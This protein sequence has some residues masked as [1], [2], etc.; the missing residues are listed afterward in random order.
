MQKI[1]SLL[2]GKSGIYSIMNIYNGKIYIGSSKDLY[3]RL[4]E[5]LHLLL[6]NSAHN[7]HLQSAWNKYGQECFIYNILELCSEESR[8]EREQFYMD[9][10]SPEYNKTP[11][12]IANFGQTVSQ[13]SRDKISKTLKEKYKSGEIKTYKQEHA[14]IPI[15]IYNIN[16]LKLVAECKC[17]ADAL[18][19]L[20]NNSGVNYKEWSL[21]RNT[22][23]MSETKLSTKE[24]LL[25]CINKNIK[26]YKG[27][28]YLIVEKNNSI[29]YYRTT[30]ECFEDTGI[31]RSMIMKNRKST[32]NNPYYPKRYNVKLYFSDVY[33]P[34]KG[35]AVP[36]EESLEELSGKFEETPNFEETFN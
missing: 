6:R 13:E 7:K 36:I 8:F 9:F 23:T 4:Y 14:W 34:V 35:E 10:M 33:I 31:S 25:N 21:I 11:Q 32:L 28:G 12:V 22:Y 3:N 29:K 19:L 5:H 27:G 24:E 16:T 2:R 30:E 17:K 26:Q 1:N 20:Y 15:Y 18:R